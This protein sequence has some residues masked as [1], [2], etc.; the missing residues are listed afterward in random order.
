MDNKM[1]LA[2][3][4]FSDEIDDISYT[5]F[6]STEEA[7]DPFSMVK[8]DSLSPR[9]KRKAYKIQKRHEGEDGTKS[10][11]LDPEVVN[12]YSL[13]DIVNPPYDLD[14]LAK[15]Y[16][17]SAIHC[18][19]INAR[20]M[21]TVGLGF[22]FS[23]TLKSRRRIEKAQDDPAKLERTRKNL[24]DLRE[25]LEV[26]FEDLN[27]EETLI[28]TLVRVWQD[29]LTVGN[30]YLEIGRNNSGKVGYIGHIPATM[31]RVRRHRDG[32]VQ[33]SRANK[34]Q[35]VF[36]RN[37]QDLEMK[38]P[39]NSDPNPNE[40]IHF[41]MYSPNNTY[42]GIP[43]AVSAAA[44]I[45]G[46]KFAKEYNIDYF[47]N[48]AIPRYAIILKGAKLSNRSKMEL[49]N[50]F[51][52]EVKGRNHGTLI[53][54]LPAGI[55]GD[56]DIKFE[57]LEAGIQDASFDKYRKSNRDEILIANRVP[58]PKV[59][60]YDNANLAVSRDADKTFKIQVIGP[61]QAIIEKKINRLLAEF[62][63]LLQFKLKKIDLLDEDMESRIYD[64]YLRTEVVSPNEVRSKIGLPE[65]SQGDDMLPFPTKVKQENGGAPIGNSNNSSS[66]PPKSRSDSGAT[67]SGVQGT[68]DQKERGQSQ[69][70]GDNTDTVKVFEGEN[71]E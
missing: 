42:Y 29:C 22:E 67:P 45:V 52:T 53:V 13:W 4:D 1:V 9:M 30:G 71:N 2:E 58:A 16:D 47:E 68:G 28:E 31:V 61:D 49:V 21:N 15:L 26:L 39:I 19:A 3:Q 44:A 6:S 51:R 48:K 20:V 23:E 34:I 27:V 12:G 66:E 18:A 11:Y 46:D 25:E 63:D 36:F 32:F 55:G 7:I 14:S 40:I 24:Q 8:I 17:Q 35:A 59:G 5:G 43:A 65:R 69:D 33:L 54:P 60:V 62:T 57:K 50:Y 56:A 38:D 37:F 41:K 70:S 64:R 10:K